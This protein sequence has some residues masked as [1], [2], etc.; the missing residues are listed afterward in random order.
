MMNGKGFFYLTLLMIM[1]T[2]T[3]CSGNNGTT[4][5]GTKEMQNMTQKLA[6]NSQVQ[7]A[8]LK[9]REL[10]MQQ[11]GNLRKEMFT[12]N[13]REQEEMIS[14]PGLFSQMADIN[15][16]LTRK[17]LNTPGD[18]QNRLLETNL[19]TFQKIKDS[20]VKRNQ[21]I[22]TLQQARDAAMKDKQ[23]KNLLLKKGMEEHYL[24]LNDPA[25]TSMVLDYTQDVQDR[26]LT[27]PTYKKRMLKNQLKG[28]KAM[29]ADSEIR[30]QL[31]A[32]MMELMKDPAMQAEMKK[33]M[34]QMMKTQI[35]KSAGQSPPPAKQ[36]SSQPQENPAK[37]SDKSP[38]F[39][40]NQ[41]QSNRSP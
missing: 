7:R 5:F 12:Q 15:I 24:A 10:T 33:M 4:Q 8:F 38:Q 36:P 14:D 21:L 40:P 26:M 37:K 28:L 35:K 16:N 3:A 22:Q 2:G 6:M 29:A 9:G 27:S 17:T 32:F 18:M 25:V 30:P 39:S 23:M 34:M 13:L 20:P 1:L 31:M 41:S 11:D 19:E